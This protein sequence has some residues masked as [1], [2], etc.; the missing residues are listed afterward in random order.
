[1]VL[2]YSR[3]CTITLSVLMAAKR[4]LAYSSVYCAVTRAVGSKIVGLSLGLRCARVL[5]PVLQ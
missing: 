3:Y 5:C 2:G 4:P 1:M